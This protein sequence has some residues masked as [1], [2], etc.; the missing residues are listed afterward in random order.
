MKIVCLDPGHSGCPDVG[1]VGLFTMEYKEAWK[2]ANRVKEIL[3]KTKEYIV[4]MTKEEAE[5][6]LSNSLA[7]RC[8]YANSLHVHVFVSIHLNA[9][10]NHSA[11]GTETYHYASSSKGKKLA[12]HIQKQ[13][14]ACLGFRDRGVKTANFYVLKHTHAPAVLTE[15]G[16]ISNPNEEKLMSEKIEQTAQAIA[17]GIIDY[18]YEGN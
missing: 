7:F 16:F 1:A 17:Q 5:D 11:K 12:N 3:E 8:Q 15:V 4:F 14:V 9:S 13:L 18:F 6:S 10:V 2:I